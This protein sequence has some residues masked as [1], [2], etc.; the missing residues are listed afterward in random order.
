M[1]I[2]EAQWFLFTNKE[3]KK[4]LIRNKVGHGILRW[5]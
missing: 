1:Q 4:K 2:Y 5:E 3:G